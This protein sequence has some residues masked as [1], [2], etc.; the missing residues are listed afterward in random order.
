[1]S[2]IKNG[3]AQNIKVESGNTTVDLVQAER[4]LGQAAI[5]G[6]EANPAEYNLD[7]FRVAFIDRVKWIERWAALPPKTGLGRLSNFPKRGVNVLNLRFRG[8][9][10]ETWHGSLDEALLIDNALDPVFLE[11]DEVDTIISDIYGE[12]GV[13]P[14]MEGFFGL[15]ELAWRSQRSVIT[16]Y[17]AEVVTP[18]ATGDLAIVQKRAK[19]GI[20]HSSEEAPLSGLSIAIIPHIR[21]SHNPRNGKRKEARK[22]KIPKWITE[23]SFS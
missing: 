11:P 23:P 8:L 10:T 17:E 12:L 20:L 3:P 21:E 19:T 13:S 4:D 1:M 6:G 5:Y 9:K 22:L 15:S 7:D 16:H 18:S 2:E 14:P